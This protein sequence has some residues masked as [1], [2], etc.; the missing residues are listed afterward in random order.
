MGF[1]RF[2]AAAWSAEVADVEATPRY[3][4]GA[5]R[6]GMVHFRFALE[7]NPGVEEDAVFVVF[8]NRMLASV[9]AG[10]YRE[11]LSLPVDA[12]LASDE[13]FDNLE[14]K[15]LSPKG[16]VVGRWSNEQGYPYWQAGAVVSIAFREV[17]RFAEHG[18]FETHGVSIRLEG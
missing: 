3:E 2:E 10:P 4:V 17:G 13:G 11:G 5:E 14:F 12:R 1:Q 6:R 16:C 7:E 15:L 9:Y 8:S 18:L